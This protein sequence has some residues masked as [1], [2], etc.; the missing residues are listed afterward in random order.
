[1]TKNN[2]N[3]VKYS[4]INDLIEKMILLFNKNLDTLAIHSPFG[5]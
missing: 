5:K 1:M 4:D 3:E 2:T